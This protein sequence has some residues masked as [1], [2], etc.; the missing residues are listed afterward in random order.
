MQFFANCLPCI[1]PSPE[2]PKTSYNSVIRDRNILQ[3][4][5]PVL[6]FSVTL[7]QVGLVIDQYYFKVKLQGRNRTLTAH[8]YCYRSIAAC[9][10]EAL[11]IG[12]HRKR[13]SFESEY[14]FS[15]CN[16]LSSS[17]NKLDE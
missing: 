3:A 16:I 9:I 12:K 2:A 15:S 1:R 7:Y 14:H 5:R 17:D 8:L 13:H 6:Q 4:H 10:E 11:L